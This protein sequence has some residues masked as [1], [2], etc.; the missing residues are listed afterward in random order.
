[1]RGAIPIIL[2]ANI[3]TCATALLASMGTSREGKQVALAHLLFKVVGVLIFLP[4]LSP[5]G[6]FVEGTSESIGRQIANAHTL[7]NVINTLLF[8]P[9]VLIMANCIKRLIPARPEGELIKYLDEKV[10]D[11]NEGI[12]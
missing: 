11:I 6:K 3:G 12:K 8:L 2:G 1:M 4:L 10:L 9:F 5:F 7:F